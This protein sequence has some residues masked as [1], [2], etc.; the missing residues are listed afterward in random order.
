MWSRATCGLG[1]P[2]PAKPHPWRRGDSLRT[3]V[4]TAGQ[5]SIFLAPF[6]HRCN[7]L[8][9][10]YPGAL[11]PPISYPRRNHGARSHPPVLTCAS[12]PTWPPPPTHA[13]IAYPLYANTTASRILCQHRHATGLSRPNIVMH[14]VDAAPQKCTPLTKQPLGVRFRHGRGPQ[15]PGYPLPPVVYTD[16]SDI[17]GHAQLG[18]TVVHISTRTAIYIDATGC[19]ETRTIMRA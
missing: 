3:P 19:E 9:E 10:T 18:A 5:G 6:P 8:R 12:H 7:W 17:K 16:G 4:V 2:Q 1:S 11:G 15:Q 13:P 14:G